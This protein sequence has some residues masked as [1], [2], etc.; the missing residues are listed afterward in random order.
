MIRNIGQWAGVVLILIGINT[1]ASAQ[2]N[3]GGAVINAKTLYEQGKLR[4][5]IAE[6]KPCLTRSFDRTN[7]WQGY[8]LLALS[9]LALNDPDNAR[10]SAEDML[11]INPQYTPSRLKDPK[12]FID[13]VNSI[14]VIPKFS[15]GLSASFGVNNSFLE[16]GTPYSI[17]DY[18]KTYITKP[19]LQFGALGGYNLN[20]YLDIGLGIYGSGKNYDIIYS[21][22]GYDVTLNEKLWYLEVPLILKYT[23]GRGRLRPYI[24]A[25]A[26]LGSLLS[27][28][29][30]FNSTYTATG[31]KLSDNNV[32]TDDR[33]NKINYGLIGG[34]G[35]TYKVGPGHFALDIRYCYGLTNIV[36]GANRYADENIYFKYYYLDDDLKISNSLISIGY[37][38]YLNYK[39]MRKKK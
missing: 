3:C 11:E 14:T 37:V 35:L 25:G 12:D 10:K 4:E 8:K 20:Q 23:F 18:T 39:V 2:D 21:T 33:R 9:Y 1:K 26:Y 27:A 22:N 13:L 19:G 36:N 32:S 24:E 38:Y 31:D 15:L 17:S 6:L 5:V 16:I 7:L 30:D 29:S 34:G 28:N